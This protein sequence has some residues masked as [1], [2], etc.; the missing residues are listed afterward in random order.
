MCK[1][2]ICRLSEYSKIEVVFWPKFM[3]EPYSESRAS[4]VSVKVETAAEG[5]AMTFLRGFPDILW[6][7][8]FRNLNHCLSDTAMALFGP[9]NVARPDLR[10][11]LSPD[12]HK[13]AIRRVRSISRCSIVIGSN[14]IVRRRIETLPFENFERSFVAC[15]W[16]LNVPKRKK[17]DERELRTLEENIRLA[18][19]R[20]V[21]L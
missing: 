18:K 2:G 13:A 4:Q 3:T 16:K 14:S 11:T 15:K 6:E 9:R 21:V 5:V 8:G 20:L 12:R 7:A 19:K 10:K 1:P 17:K